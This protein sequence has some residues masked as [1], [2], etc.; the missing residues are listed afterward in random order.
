MG[1]DS[2]R[3]RG[4]RARNGPTCGTECARYGARM[5]NRFSGVV[6]A[7]VWATALLCGGG[8]RAGFELTV[9]LPAARFGDGPVVVNRESLEA[10]ASTWVATGKLVGGRMRLSVEAQPGLF[11]VRVGETEVPFVAAEG[12]SLQL[13]AAKEERGL[14][15]VGGADQE[16]FAGYEAFRNESLARLVF[17]VRETIAARQAVGDE[18]EVERLTEKEV[19][20]YREHRRELN[21]HT[22]AKLRGSPALYAASLRWDGDYRLDELAAAVNEF[23]KQHPGTE[24][25]Q[26]MEERI[27]RFRV[28][29][30]GAV[31]PALSGP[32]A[33]G[34]VISLSEL[35]GRI[36]LVDFWASWCGP[37][38]IENRSYAEL[39]R[40]HRAAGFEIL[41][42][43]VDQDARSWKAAIAKDGAGWRHI[44]D[45]SGWKSSLAASYGVTALPASFLLDREGRIIAKDL[46]GK[47]L[48]AWL[49][50]ELT[51]PG[52][53]AK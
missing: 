13:V 8:L 48:A 28:T 39:Y 52:R 35:R 4:A 27:A 47:Q 5:V 2:A 1:D 53:A 45:L 31:A 49:A 9:V 14:R 26:R 36:V 10:R 7:G 24:I 37:C 51:G 11:A 34:A 41:A 22:L 46:R 16:L 20:A 3:R 30:I 32:S 12:Q 18:A 23:A 42:V 40:R 44:S 19:A 29:A 33:E 38:R 17:P 25:A 15:V 43:S 50:R 6:R 21:D